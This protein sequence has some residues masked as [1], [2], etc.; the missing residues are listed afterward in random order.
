MSQPINGILDK[1]KLLGEV[2]NL[3]ASNAELRTLLKNVEQ[4]IEEVE[5][6]AEEAVAS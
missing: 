2:K 1:E 4:K 5:T 6:K 3:K